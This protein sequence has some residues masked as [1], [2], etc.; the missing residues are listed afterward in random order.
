MAQ[1]ITAADAVSRARAHLGVADSAPSRVV[2]VQ[3]LDR[4]DRYF[5]VALGEGTENVGLATVGANSGEI[6]TSARITGGKELNCLDARE[7]IRLAGFHDDA[8]AELVWQPCRI[9]QSPFDP[10]WEVR[11]PDAT[12][13]VDQRGKVWTKLLPG[14]PGG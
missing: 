12:A 11:S 9:S 4:A 6:Q 10:F 7:A 8:V 14:G 13:Y 1:G 2:L 5:L 3:R